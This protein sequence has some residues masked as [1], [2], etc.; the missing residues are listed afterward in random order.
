MR[1]MKPI[2]IEEKKSRKYRGAIQIF[3]FILIGLI[4][5]NHAL[6]EKGIIIPFISTASLHAICP[7][8]GVVSIYQFFTVGTFVQKI[9]ESAF[10]LMM[11]TFIMAILFGAVFCGWI[12]PLG[13]IQ[14]WIGK[15]GRRLFKQRYN[16]FIPVKYDTYLRY[17]RY[18]VLLWVL[19]ITAVSGKLLF[20]DIDPYHA[21]FNFWSGEVSQT[22][23]II[24]GI[25]L[26]ASLYVERPWCKYACPLGAVYGISNLFRVFKIRRNET[27]CISCG[28]CNQSCPMNIE[29]S[30]QKCIINHQCIGCLQCTSDISCPVTGTVEFSTKGGKYHENQTV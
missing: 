15:I 7:F 10:V 6:T 22:G 2:S 23:L 26:V 18:L 13:S 29:V 28:I 12:C 9:H 16:H 21:L 20:G 17:I 27:S 25:V 8:G 3:F 14:E 5:V 4:S 11:I 24:L 19:Y 1:S 30:E